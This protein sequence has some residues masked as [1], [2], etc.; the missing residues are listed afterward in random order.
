MLKK[1]HKLGLFI[2]GNQNDLIIE[3]KIFNIIAFFAAFTCF[4]AFIVNLFVGFPIIFNTVILVCGSI[5][6][7]FFYLSSFRKITRPLEIPLQVIAISLL[8]ISWF[9]NQ[10]IEGSVPCYFLLLTFAFIYSNSQKKYWLILL[11][12]VTLVI[13]LMLFQYFYPASI[14]R[15]PN[16]AAQLFDL[17]FN[18]IISLAILGFSS[19][20]LKQNYDN[21][22]QKVEFNAKKLEELNATKDKFFSIISHDLKNPFN[23]LLGLSRLLKSNIDKYSREELMEKLNAI[24]ESS[25]RGYE[26]LDNLL[27]WS[28]AQTGK[29]QFTPENLKLKKVVDDCLCVIENQLA[30]K[31]IIIQSE[32]TDD[33]EVKADY[34]MLK[35]I[36]RNLITNA[37][38]YSHQDSTVTIKAEE[39]DKG[40]VEISIIDNGVGIPQEEIHKLFRIDTKYTTP[41]TSNESGTGLGLLLCREFV[42][43]HGGKIWVESKLDFG[44]IFKFSLPK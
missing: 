37:V 19:I 5:F 7:L 32:F 13:I 1:L 18:L 8:T 6:T 17:S 3:N 35:I 9:F 38:K 40:T 22:R 11:I 16:K 15:Y 41:G 20:L 25:K 24:E 30:N 12:Y 29:I 39:M 31:K 14:I 21:E 27:E 10:G 43:K 4:S 34:N 36:L 33:F 28:M 23:S 44:S 26:L 2:S 42:E